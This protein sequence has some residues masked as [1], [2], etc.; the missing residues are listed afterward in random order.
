MRNG[1]GGAFHSMKRKLILTFHTFQFYSITGLHITALQF[2][3]N[4]PQG[5]FHNKHRHRQNVTR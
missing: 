2:M 3:Q 1:P 4:G 5:V